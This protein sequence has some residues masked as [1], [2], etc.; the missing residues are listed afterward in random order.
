MLLF[1]FPA[2][3]PRSG[4][5]IALAQFLA[6]A[7]DVA[8]GCEVRKARIFF[9]GFQRGALALSGLSYLVRSGLG[10]AKDADMPR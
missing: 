3:R 8:P 5:Y 10:L 7:E 9:V 1:F 6:A 2:L 4:V